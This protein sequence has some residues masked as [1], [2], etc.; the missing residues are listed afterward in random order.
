[1][2]E[3]GDFP[4]EIH[5]LNLHKQPLEATHN[6]KVVGSNPA[7]ATTYISHQRTSEVFGCA[8]FLPKTDSWTTFCQ[9]IVR[10][11]VREKRRNLI[12]LPDW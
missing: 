10:G 1:M 8:F 4:A 5:K 3:I 11:Y 2:P 6:P 12:F 9:Q 7:P